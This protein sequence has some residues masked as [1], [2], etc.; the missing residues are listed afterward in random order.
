MSRFTVTFTTDNHLSK[1][2]FINVLGKWAQQPE[3]KFVTGFYINGDED[4]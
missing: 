2:A 4:D 1:Q 3:N